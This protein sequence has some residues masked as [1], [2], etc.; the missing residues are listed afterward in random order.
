VRP[1]HLLQGRLG[2][3][4]ACRRLLALGYDVLA[5]RHRGRTGELDLIAY[6]GETLVFVEVK[7]RATRLFG[8]P[9]EFVDR[10]KRQRMKEAAREFVARHDLGAWRCR[11]DVV[12][13]VAPGT[14][15]EEITV[16]R[17]AF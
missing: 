4:L 15:R 9:W 13:V 7:T 8:E 10:E 6:D 16:I 1:A 3:R 2:E 5:R 17:D 12:S 11:F 14:P